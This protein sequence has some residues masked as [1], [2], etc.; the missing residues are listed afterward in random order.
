MRGRRLVRALVLVVVVGLASTSHAIVDLSGGWDVDFGSAD[1][2]R[3]MMIR[4]TDG[5]LDVTL[6]SAP[7]PGRATGTIDQSTRAVHVGDPSFTG[8]GM[9]PSCGGL[10]IDAVVSAD[11]GTMSGDLTVA[12]GFFHGFCF[13]STATFVAMHTTCGNGVV[14]PGE[15][16]DT[17]DIFSGRDCCSTRCSFEP[18]TTFCT[19]PAAAALGCVP[20]S[21]CSG[22]SA[23]CE[24]PAFTDG[25][26]DGIPD[27]CDSCD[28][29]STVSM[30]R[31]RRRGGVSV[32]ARIG[33]PS[34]GVDPL[35]SGL[36][37][38]FRGGQTDN[39]TAIELWPGAPES[40]AGWTIERPGGRWRFADDGRTV[41]ATVRAGR[42]WVL[43]RV[44]A[45]GG[46]YESIAGDARFVTVEFLRSSTERG[47]CAEIDLG[48]SACVARKN[49]TVCR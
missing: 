44:S 49:A 34:E 25:D 46:F 16:C 22:S 6:E 3:R 27:S 30:M 48:S 23:T 43:V 11:G 15:S 24:S 40:G 26:G 21:A 42:R 47:P 35:A 18:T 29:G 33:R 36:T 37:V 19:S 28:G 1:T 14:D 20:E 13:L 32:I 8:S 38:R 45:R 2:T 12:G 9:T 7:F 5:M 31:V 17:G 4:Q 41:K 39:Y 10:R